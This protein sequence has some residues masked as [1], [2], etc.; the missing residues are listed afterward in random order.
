MRVGVALVEAFCV[1]AQL[2]SFLGA[3]VTCLVDLWVSDV[4]VHRE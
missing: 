2:G 4:G 3:L 1:G